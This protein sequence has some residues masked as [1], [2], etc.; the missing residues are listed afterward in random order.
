VGRNLVFG[1]V[2]GD[3]YARDWGEGRLKRRTRG[4]KP[5]RGDFGRARLPDEFLRKEPHSL[6]PRLEV[7]R[8][9]VL[10]GLLNH[11]SVKK[12]A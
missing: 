6:K 5:G 1:G 9:E 12:A 3:D 11:Y 10:V 4:R 2:E 8:E 7:M